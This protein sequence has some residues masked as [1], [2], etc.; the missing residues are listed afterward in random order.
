[1][2]SRTR[3]KAKKSGESVF[4]QSVVE[5]LNCPITAALPVVPV[6]AEDGRIYERAAIK[7]WIS[8][9]ARS[10]ITNAPMGAHLAEASAT[11]RPLVLSAI[12]NG[13]VEDESAAAWHLGSAKAKLAGDLPGELS[14]VKIDLDRA[15]AL[16]STPETEFL[17]RACALKL[18]TESLLK[19]SAAAGAGDILATIL[20]GGTAG[21]FGCAVCCRKLDVNVT[22]CYRSCCS[23][24]ICDSCWD[25]IYEKPCPLCHAPWARDDAETL[26]RIRRQAETEV[27]AAVYRLT[28]AYRC[29]DYGLA[30]DWKK[31]ATL[32][33]RAAELGDSRASHEL[34]RMHKHG[35][36]VEA[37]KEKAKQLFRVAADRGYANAQNSLAALLADDSPEEAFELH[38]RA[39]DQGL[40]RAEYNLGLCFEHGKGVEADV[41]AAKRWFA[42][43]AAKGHENSIAALERLR[44]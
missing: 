35:H 39:A 7:R 10:P 15:G 44:A 6:L 16:A 13:V 26:A 40:T 42:R 11:T 25:K 30:E 29:G 5:S 24:D 22:P 1:M 28:N 23:R 20:G 21:E 34:A 38:K 31:A 8:T 33:A 43:A 4:S 32:Y 41:V 37:D 18:E 2:S 19:E 14:S 3:K 17:R 9:K 12:E 36:G 27:P